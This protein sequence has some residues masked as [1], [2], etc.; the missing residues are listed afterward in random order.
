MANVIS[1]FPQKTPFFSAVADARQKPSTTGGT[2]RA[3]LKYLAHRKGIYYFKRKV[4]VRLVTPRQHWLDGSRP[5]YR[6]REEKNRGEEK[7]ATW[8]APV[9][10]G[11]NC[12]R[13]APTCCSAVVRVRRRPSG[14]KRT[15]C[16]QTL[17]A[18]TAWYV[19][20]NSKSSHTLHCLWA[21][22]ARRPGA[23]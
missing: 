11:R 16:A 9:C 23:Q 2:S 13:P 6:E 12:P 5:Q 14:R 20:G 1:L 4:P 15:P 22:A 19:E 3:F 8:S 17:T 21:S 18:R 10:S 7:A